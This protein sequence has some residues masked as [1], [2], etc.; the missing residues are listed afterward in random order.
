M[1]LTGKP[2]LGRLPAAP[3]VLPDISYESGVIADWLKEREGPQRR[4][5]Q[6]AK[7]LA[8]AVK[9]HLD[10]VRPW[11]IRRQVAA[12]TGVS[13]PQIDVVVSQRQANG[14]INVWTATVKG[15]INRSRE[16]VITQKFIQPSQELLDVVKRAT[17]QRLKDQLKEA[18]KAK[19]EAANQR[20]SERNTKPDLSLAPPAPNSGMGCEVCEAEAALAPLPLQVLSKEFK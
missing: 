8:L 9:L 7:V 14:D 1:S 12:H 3:L 13:L 10:G 11:P 17:A 18:K 2:K 6:T 19:L 20:R 5:E 4:P 15:N 16:S